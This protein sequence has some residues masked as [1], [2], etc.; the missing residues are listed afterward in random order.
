[1]HFKGEENPFV[2]HGQAE[3]CNYYLSL[4]NQL[5]P[6]NCRTKSSASVYGDDP[7]TML[8]STC[9]SFGPWSSS[10]DSNLK[11]ALGD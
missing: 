10:T 4:N 3:V 5:F 6:H 8:D 7:I 9:Q 11:A 1:M 2:N